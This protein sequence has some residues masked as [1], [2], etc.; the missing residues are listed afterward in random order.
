MADWSVAARS[1]GSGQPVAFA[2]AELPG[3][4]SRGTP[5]A[6]HPPAGEHRA[7]RHPAFGTG[8][9]FGHP[10]AGPPGGY[11]DRHRLGPGADQVE[12]AV[13]RPPSLPASRPIC[14]AG[15][16]D[17]IPRGGALLPRAVP[18][19]PQG[20]KEKTFLPGYRPGP[21]AL[22]GILLP[23]RRKRAV[24]SHTRPVFGSV[25]TVD[26]SGRLPRYARLPASAR[27][28]RKPDPP[29]LGRIPL[30]SP[31]DHRRRGKTAHRIQRPVVLGLRLPAREGF[32]GAN[33]R[34]TPAPG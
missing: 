9:P 27:P 11:P 22:G 20:R 29:S 6:A 10:G 19:P 30:R 5:L 34:A 7:D 3:E 17:K 1:L 21:F 28:R 14:P 24:R 23:G 4:E 31:G 8:L 15:A 12:Y 32:H 2:G 33:L 13:D 18:G 25:R 26:R 16:G